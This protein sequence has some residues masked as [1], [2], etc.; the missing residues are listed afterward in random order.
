MLAH[1]SR[2]SGW[3]KMNSFKK[4]ISNVTFK[5]SNWFWQNQMA[6]STVYTLSDN[7]LH[8]DKEIPISEFGN[9]FIFEYFIVIS[10]SIL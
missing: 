3:T 8:S 6:K 1:L 9:R 7:P 2:A 10:I 4:V 5:D